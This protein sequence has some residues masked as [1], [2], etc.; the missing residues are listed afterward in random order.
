MKTKLTFIL[1]ICS[2]LLALQATAQHNQLFQWSGG[3]GAWSDAI[4]WSVD[5]LPANRI[6]SENDNVWIAAEHAAIQISVPKQLIVHSLFVTGTEQVQFASAKKSEIWV[7]ENTV[8]SNATIVDNAISL[9]LKGKGYYSIPP[10]L[11]RKENIEIGAG[12]TE[13]EST[14]RAGSCPF[15]TIVP[16]PTAPTCNGFSNGVASILEPTDGVVPYTYQWIGGPMTR[17]WSNLGAGTYTV[18]VI[19]M[20]QG[21]VPCNVDVFVNEP[22]PLTVFGMNATDPLCSDVCNGTAAPIV[23][24]GNGNYTLNWSSGEAGFTA[25]MLCPT[26]VL[27]IEDQLGCTFD[28]TYV[29]T[30]VPAPIEFNAVLGN[31]TCFGAAD[32]TI[33]L[34]TTGGTPP[35]VLSWIGPSGFTSTA[36]NLSGLLPGSYTVSLEDAN[37]CIASESF[38]LTQNPVLNASSSKVDNTCFGVAEGS[39]TV[40]VTGGTTPYNFSWTGSDGFTST[41]QN[42]QNLS[43]G[44]YDL[45]ITDAEG[46]IFALSATIAEPAEIAVSFTPIDVLCFEGNTGSVTATA[47]MG[48]PGYSYSWSGPNAFAATGATISNLLAG[49]YFI[50]VMDG[51]A[52]IKL[53]SVAISAPDSLLLEGATTEVTCTNGNDG[54]IDLTV[55][56]G[57]PTYMVSWSGPSGFSSSNTDISGLTSGIFS[58]TI[59]DANGCMANIS[60][61]LANPAPITI[62]ASITSASCANNN[63]GAIDI[64][65]MG[66]MA[67]FTFAWT[68]PLSFSSTNQNISNRGAGSYTVIVTDSNGCTATGTYTITTPAAVTATFVTA[69]A[70]CFNAADGAITATPSGGQAP[71]TFLWIGPAG[72]IAT[73]QNIS[74]LIAG[75]YGLQITDANGCSGFSNVNLTQPP[76]INI[77]GPRTP[78]TCFGGSNGAIDAIVSGGTPGY[79]YS[80]TSPEGFTASTQDLSGIPAG[81]YTLVVTDAISC[82]ATRTF[83]ITQ[84]TEILSNATTTNVLCA[85]DNTG[86]ISTSIAGGTAPY[87]IQWS[88]PAGF[89]SMQTSIADLN[90]G[91]Y[92]LTITDNR[93]CVKTESFQ[94]SET[95]IITLNASVT[96]ITCFGDDNGAIDVEVSGGLEPYAISWSGADG[97]T[98]SVLIIDDLQPGDYTLNITDS[99]NCSFDSTF[100][101][102]SPDSLSIGAVATAISCKDADDGSILTNITGGTTPISIEW[103]GANGF[104]STD[105]SIS[106]LAAGTYVIIAMDNAGCTNSE[107]I[108]ITEPDSILLDVDITQ[109]SCLADNGALSV[110]VSGGTIATDYIYSWTNGLGTEIGTTASLSDLAPDSYTI[111]VIDDN[112]CTASA[113]LLLERV[114]INLAADII[115]ASCSNSSDG[116]ISILATGGV[117]PYTYAW[118]GGGGFAS[119]NDTITGLTAGI[120]Q[121]EITDAAGCLTT[122]TFEIAAPPAITIA[123]VITVESCPG[124]NTGSIALN[125]SGGSPGYLIAW[126]GPDGFTSAS[127]TITDLSAGAYQATITDVNG[128]MAD[129]TIALNNGSNF[130][131]ALSGTS[132]A[133]AGE[134]TGAIDATVTP[135]SG[136]PEPFNFAWTANNG[137]TANTEDISNLPS[138][139]Y[140]LAVTGSSGCVIRDSIILS[141]PD[142]LLLEL[143]LVNSTCE[144]ADGSASV[145]ASGG[146]GSLSYAWTDAVGDTLATATSLDNIT[147]GTYQI[148]VS[149]SAGCSISETFVLSDEDA[150]VTGII[151]RP[152][153][154]GGAEGTIDISVDGGIAPFSYA[155]SGPNGFTSTDEDIS[156]LPAG[157]YVVAATGDNGCIYGATFTV[158][159]PAPI[160]AAVTAT[161]ES[162][163]GSDGSIALVLSGGTPPYTIA[164]TG[165]DGFTASTETIENLLQGTYSYTITDV[166]G[167][168][169]IDSVTIG[170]AESISVAGAVTDVVCGGEL[171]GAIATNISG[172]IT[173]YTFSW[174]D[175][176]GFTANT[177]ELTDVAAGTYTLIVTD[178]TDCVSSSTFTITENPAI[179]ASFE[180]VNPDCSNSNGS[181]T[182]TLTGGVVSSDYF[183]SWTDQDGN[184][185]S[186]TLSISSLPTGAYDF[187]ASD[188]NGC[189]FDTTIILSNPNSEILAEIT[190]ISCPGA[191]D[192]ALELTISGV[193]E[194]FTLTWSGPDGYSSAEASISDLDTGI[195]TYVI[196]AADSCTY[197]ESFNLLDPDSIAIAATAEI[198]CFG[199]S[200]GSIEIEITGGIEPYTAAWIGPDGFTS[201]EED[202]VDIGAGLYELTI[203]DANGCQAVDSVDVM[204]NDEI[205]TLAV[206]TPTLCIGDSTAAIDLTV[207]GGA[208]PYLINWSGDNGFTFIGEDLADI[209]PGDYTVSILDSLGCI[210][211]Q[212]FQVRPP[213]SLL[214]S[215]SITSVGCT[216]SGS[217][218][219]ISLFISGGM[220]DY[221]VSWTGPNGFTASTPAIF[222]LETG[223]YTYEV[224]DANGCVTTASIELI[225]VEPLMVA[226][227]LSQVNCFGGSDGGITAIATGGAAP[228]VYQWTGEDGFA[229]SGSQLDGLLAGDYTLLI[230]DSA[231]CTL[232]ENYEI[233]Q[234]DSIIIN[235]ISLVDATCNTSDDGSIEIEISGGV[236]PYSGLWTG[237]DGFS[238]SQLSIDSLKIGTYNALITDANGCEAMAEFEIGFTLLVNVD[239]GDDLTLCLS[240][241]PFSVIATSESLDLFIWSDI[242]GAVL[243]TDS[244]LSISGDAGA[245]T[246]FVTGSNGICE[247]TD[248]LIVDLRAGPDVDAG[249]DFEAFREENFTLGGSP[250]STNAS[251]Y[252]WSP[253]ATGSFDVFA[254]NP[255][256]FALESTTFT[257]IATDE[258]GCSSTDS[259]FV[260]IVPEVLI[261]SGF[262][263][264]S[265][266]IND[267]WIIDNI[268]L[269]PSNTVQIFNRWGIELYQVNG[270]QMSQ[271]WD[272]TYEGKAVP[273]GTYYY[274]INLNDPRFPDPITGPLTITR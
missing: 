219:S 202:L 185:L 176:E 144:Q 68:G 207:S 206:L 38:T 150:N 247:D 3:S 190:G 227:S 181:I 71:Y 126:S 46:C 83:N 165:D 186:P 168:Q 75:S 77:T 238:T 84:P 170:I 18:I 10:P 235:T 57:T 138:G 166:N 178:A 225:E 153:C 199:E 187:T 177:Q 70:T 189:A 65:L 108:E 73:S 116:Q 152:L 180:I 115:D 237:P 105:P 24:G 132:P 27:N 134:N 39:I 125:L 74:N 81:M 193:A 173:P 198:T 28:T 240:A 162:C 56:G 232:A 196:T 59:E 233:I 148:S 89:T 259:V 215:E 151:T 241:L 51:N 72:F 133:C 64:T 97:F 158:S 66:G 58:A 230:S 273:M 119:A 135:L 20:G 26:F 93:G 223:T 11:T 47:S 262:T 29:F 200:S 175:G 139:T 157:D 163:N 192:G 123:A 61:E 146:T 155:W 52:C 194:P 208:S 137:F 25:S 251:T 94:I 95:V 4:H 63:D 42:L 245:N 222:G 179:V 239:A 218:G 8:L 214:V 156:D 261:T 9:K 91:S 99:N 49:T 55:S 122:E 15:F 96:P 54:A 130:N 216:A 226:T 212:D 253:N 106:D 270:Y 104:T 204:E 191:A 33:D 129:S 258:N 171:T 265:D 117:E 23:I 60:F 109:P 224:I 266:G 242:D 100:A 17:Q 203:I 149:D 255:T 188:D 127:S 145:A 271:A 264:N 111:L 22:G 248:T 268:E 267:R 69:N 41:D 5:G 254:S 246:Y 6:P 164:W 184:S 45:T 183:I 90:A 92:Q 62:A 21:A 209:A 79:T 102:I 7:S 113:T 228:Y 34:N 43:S 13:L 121:L 260:Y 85:G 221:S 80:W 118:T 107:T 86:A 182:T 19:D 103:N 1:Y 114:T 136:S 112:G 257:V 76:K 147:A 169:L 48:T 272:G 37:N 2:T 274:A 263:P 53:D 220:P 217:A 172:G 32:G 87:T 82:T 174:S 140:V 234:N 213:D 67:P 250:T 243:S 12:L 44:T 205:N 128:C 249:V 154:V 30:N 231:G 210:K 16:N 256:G 201:A 142:S 120:Y 35:Y 252:A 36:G 197:S 143:T 229:A 40:T 31:I 14:A 131:I 110:S 124:D 161:G 160:S 101:V 211:T 141:E 244:S 50:E 159:D 195:Y 88:G 167:C 78:V 98:A 236:A 269:Y